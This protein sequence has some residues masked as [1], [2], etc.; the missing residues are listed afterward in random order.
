MARVK[1]SSASTGASLT[2][3]TST[4]ARRV[5]IRSGQ[6]PKALAA[7]GANESTKA[8]LKAVQED[9]IPKML[10]SSLRIAFD[11]ALLF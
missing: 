8:F 5:M 7:Y 6:R 3:Y 10:L 9:N 2:L 4:R 1:A 11:L